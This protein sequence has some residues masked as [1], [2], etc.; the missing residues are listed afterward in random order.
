VFLA[1]FF[2]LAE[3]SGLNVISEFNLENTTAYGETE[4]GDNNS[5]VMEVSG[6]NIEADEKK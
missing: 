3:R 2:P 5:N 1:K 4:D 6:L